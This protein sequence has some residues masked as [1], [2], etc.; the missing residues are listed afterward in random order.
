MARDD[1]WTLISEKSSDLNENWRGDASQGMRLIKTLVGVK[2]RV[3]LCDIRMLD[4]G[5][6]W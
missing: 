2:Q 1:W 3:Y 4:V 6:A 5:E